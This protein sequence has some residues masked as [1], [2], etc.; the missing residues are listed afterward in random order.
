MSENAKKIACQVL[1]ISGNE[2]SNLMQPVFPYSSEIDHN[3]QNK[4]FE[5]VFNKKLLEEENDEEWKKNIDD[6]S[7]KNVNNI[8]TY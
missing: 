1:E 4:K 2:F 6:I 8:Y 3:I 5:K 7:K